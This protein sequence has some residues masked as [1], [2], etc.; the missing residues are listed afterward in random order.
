MIF[1]SRPLSRKIKKKNVF[2]I[3]KSSIFGSF[4]APLIERRPNEFFFKKSNLVSFQ[5]LQLP[6]ITKT[7]KTN[8][9]I[10]TYIHLDTYVHTN[11]Q[12]LI[13]RSLQYP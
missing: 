5:I 10:C 7:S 6:N 9:L 8:D 3:E 4:W 2:K 1:H 12:S 13:R 11:G